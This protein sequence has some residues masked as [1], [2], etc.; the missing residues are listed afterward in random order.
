MAIQPPAA[1]ATQ[2]ST[3]LPPAQK[4]G[5]AG[6]SVGCLGCIG[7]VVLVVLLVLGSGY[8]F[9]I[10]QASAGVA[11]PAALLVASTPVDVGHNDSG[12]QPATSGQSLDAGSSVRTGH[13][14]H[15]TVQFPDGSLMRVSPDTTITIQAAQLNNAGNLKSATIQQKIGRTLSEVQHLAGGSTF[16]VGGHSVSAEVRGTEFEV[17]VR[18]DSSNQI[19]V[20]DGT[21]KVSGQTTVT[22]NAGEQVDADPNGKLAP[23]RSITPDKADP[24]QLASQCGKAVSAGTAAGTLQTTTGDNLSTGQT[25]EVDYRSPG[26]TV[27]VALCYPGSS[28]TLTVIDP[29]GGQHP[30]R[31]GSST[32]NGPPGL[33]RAIVH[34]VDVPG[35]EPFAVSFATNASCA[36]G[37]VDTGTVVRQ[38]LSSD[39]LQASMAQSGVT[40]ITIRIVGVSSNS[41]RLYYYSDLGGTEISWTIDFYAATPNLGAVVTQITVRGINITTQVVS[42]LTSANAS[43]SSIPQDYIVDRVYSCAASGG[44]MVIEGHRG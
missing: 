24:F 44:L 29:L 15:A 14:G 3:P 41:A 40:G 7:A 38:T 22:L 9:F 33:Y 16:Q 21:V 26:G 32:V 13:T 35:G 11:S 25:A 2:A 6:C 4:S 42:R 20:F 28:M 19:K 30:V 31:G 5:C 17:L 34:A 43:I 39:Q 27:S 36:G 10:A 12:Y 23:K 1:P 37:N 8:F 18:P